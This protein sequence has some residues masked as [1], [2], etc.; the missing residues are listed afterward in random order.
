MFCFFSF[1]ATHLQIYLFIYFQYI[2]VGFYLFIYFI[3]HLHLLVDIF[4]LLFVVFVLFLLFLYIF[5]Y[6][7]IYFISFL[8]LYQTSMELTTLNECAPIYTCLYFFMSLFG[9]LFSC[10]VI[11]LLINVFS[12]FELIVFD[13]YIHFFVYSFILLWNYLV[14]VFV[15]VCFVGLYVSLFPSLLRLFFYTKL[16]E[17]NNFK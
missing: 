9:L 6:V 11:Y 2:F 17:A 10:L 12:Y 15:F 13:S 4:I 3:I 14:F 7:S 1:L 8:S 5:P 16:N